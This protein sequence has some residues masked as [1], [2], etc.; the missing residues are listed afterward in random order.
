MWFIFAFINSWIC[1][2]YYICNQNSNLYPKQ[3]IIYRGFIAAFAATPFMLFFHH[4]FPLM[5]Y[6]IILFQGL[7]ISY[8]DRKYFEAFHNFG[9]E[10]VNAILPLTVVIT[11]FAWLLIDPALFLAYLKTPIRSIMIILTILVIVISIIKYRGQALGFKCFKYVFPLLLLSSLIDMSNKLIM[12]YADDI[13]YVAALH[14]VA[15]TGWIIGFLNLFSNRKEENILQ[16]FH[17][18]NLIQGSF[19]L[20]LVI[21]MVILNL[22]MYYTPNPAYC[23][24]VFYLSVVWIILINK[25][26]KWCGKKILYQNLDKKWIFSLLFATIVLVLITN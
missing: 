16:V 24:A 10:N 23:S 26:Q 17:P 6:V 4:L 1:A 13:L 14:R 2:I 19:I 18:K 22:A 3:F 5:F 15:L 12:N 21:S 20:W 9:A 11:F 7:I 8:M 25:I